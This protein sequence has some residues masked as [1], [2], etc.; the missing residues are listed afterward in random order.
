MTGVEQR[1]VAFGRAL[2]AAGLLA[3]TEQNERFARS[4]RW[5]DAFDTHQLYHAARTCY[6][7]RHEDQPVFDS[8]FGRFWGQPLGLTSRPQKAPRA[9]RER[10]KEQHPPTLVSFMSQRAAQSDQ[11]IELPDRTHTASDEDILQR[12]DF[13]AMTAD[14]LTQVRRTLATIRW[15]LTMRRSRRRVPSRRGD[16][17]DFRRALRQSMRSTGKI[18]A[19]PL[20]GRKVKPRPLIL[21][22]DVSGSMEIYSRIVL[23]LFH[24][25]R[26][27][28]ARTEAFAFGTRLTRITEPLKVRDLDHALDGV[29]D[30]V[31]DFAGGTRIGESLRTFNRRWAPRLLGRGAVVILISDGWER[32]DPGLLGQEM[33]RLQKRCHRLIWLNPHLGSVDYEPRAAGA[34]AALPY[35]DD[36]LSIHNMQSLRGLAEHLAAVPERKGGREFGAVAADARGVC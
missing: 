1:I 30:E 11:E 28:F 29:S 31:V 8:V 19:I 25:L 22:A 4:L 10:P 12:K 9:P 21:I 27:R 33:R 35:V 34:A 7:Y 23:Q 5:I 36:F 6:L 32:G 3:G 20:R 18:L 17:P 13:A 14:E 2:R 26:S 24:G 15:R 16:H